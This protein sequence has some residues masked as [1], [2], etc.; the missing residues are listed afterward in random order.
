MNFETKHKHFAI[1]SDTHNN[2]QNT[3]LVLEFCRKKPIDTIIHCGDFTSPGSVDLF[4]GFQII[5]TIGNGDLEIQK[6]HTT[7]S[8]LNTKIFSGFSFV[9]TINEIP[10]AATHGHITGKL[11]QLIYTTR[12][13]YIFYG[14]THRKK[15]AIIN[16]KHIINPGSLGG[17]NRGDTRSF[18]VFNL[19]DLKL[20]FIELDKI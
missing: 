7:L 6:I 14:H 5:H 3:K 1:L 2:I 19:Q 20:G 4:E 13:Q 8:N 15:E 10:F 9:G 16:R 12:A 17:T 11:D 18:C